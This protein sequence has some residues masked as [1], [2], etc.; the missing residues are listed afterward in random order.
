[1]GRGGGGEGR[2]ISIYLALERPH[3]QVQIC[4]QVDSM[5]GKDELQPLPAYCKH[6]SIQ[7]L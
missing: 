4:Q 3:S 2:G 1:M 6:S 5:L 7:L